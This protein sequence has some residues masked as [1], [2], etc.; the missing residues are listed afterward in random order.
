[1]NINRV[2]SVFMNYLNESSSPVKLAKN[3]CQYFFLLLIIIANTLLPTTGYAVTLEKVLFSKLPSNKV[4]I[5]LSG[6]DAFPEPK[7]FS[8]KS[9]ARVVFDFFGMKSALK[10]P[11]Y[12]IKI[13]A[14]DTLRVVQV[15]DRIRIV[16]NLVDS[17]PYKVSTDSN[18]F[19]ISVDP[20]AKPVQQQVKVKPFSSKPKLSNK[21]IKNID[22][23]RSEKGG[24]RIIVD[25][26]D[27]DTIVDLRQIEGE[28]VVDFKN[29]IVPEDL[30][31]RLDVTDF[32]T[33]VRAVDLFQNGENVRMIIEPAGEYQQI[34][35][36]NESIFTVILDPI[37]EEE[38]EE[39]NPA[40]EFG[41][42]GERLSMNF[43]KLEVRSALS[44]ISD[45]TGI[46]II[47]SDDVQ[48][49]LTL[50]LKDVPWDQALD[51]ILDTKGLAKRQRG[52]VIWV[53]PAQRLA[54]FERLQL[55]AS[56]TSEALEPLVSEV[57]EINY[58]KAADIRDVIL[59][60][61]GNEGEGNQPPQQ[62]LLVQP[63]AS[64]VEEDTTV[65][66]TSES[67]QI[68]ADE[69]TNSLII[70]TTATNMKS[71]KSL[72]AK[73]DS[74]VRQVMIETRIVQATDT[75]SKEL[76]SRLGFQRVTENATAGSSNL[77][78]TA[79]SGTLT[80]ANAI[81]QSL[82]D[83]TDIFTAGSPG[84]N[85][86]LGANGAAGSAPASYAF[87]L[88]KAGTGYANI[89]SLELSALEAEGRG[90]IVSSPRLVT[91]NQ[92]V[93]AITTG[94]TRFITTGVSVDGIPIT[95]TRNALLGMRV[96][97]QITPD[98]NVVLDV[99]ITQDT[100]VS[101]DVI[102]RNNISTQVTAENGE[103]IIIGGIYE[104]QQSD[105]VTKVPVLGDIPVV[106]RLFK[107]KSKSDNRSELLIFL[108]PK[109]INQ[110][111][112]IN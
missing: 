71:I 67:L 13:G 31:K 35:F 49:D 81:Q 18:Q 30:E 4:Q 100:F 77:G 95:E 16:M 79:T 105:S 91:S 56:K 58:A 98:D 104:E 57:I 59:E 12:N 87:S 26:S 8:T 82:L 27:S 69:R 52:N 96:T 50:N 108:T 3:K 40:N 19:I 25:L 112:S 1:M 47:A 32:A 90:K 23:R 15:A 110:E 101:D 70:T 80:N 46:N 34:S 68:T 61:R 55:E 73:L 28:I 37:E 38:K 10:S 44:V 33:P 103:T 29:S 63:G 20:I 75:F 48:G 111:L 62:I 97:P 76:G 86:D 5:N 64:G 43:Q 14:V 42:T 84:L 93:A 53:A 36:Q 106:G 6:S 7:V 17:A 51:V 2:L 54:E 92:K 22:F 94:T 78:N 89:I 109:I 83:G 45:F 11:E 107:K 65:S 9:P 88:F 72:I 85:V 39:E 21:N 99:S 24:G 60:E 74:P 66:D 102:R 41:Y